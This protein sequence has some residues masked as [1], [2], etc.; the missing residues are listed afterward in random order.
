MDWLATV[1]ARLGFAVDQ[2]L[3]YGTGGLAFSNGQYRNHDF[4]N[5]GS[6]GTGLMDAKGDMGTGWTVGGGL[7]LALAPNWS[8]SAEYL[9]VRFDGKNYSGTAFNQEN[10]ATNDF[11]FSANPAEFNV[12]R[13]GLNYQFGGPS[14]SPSADSPLK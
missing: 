6:C 1:R 4:C 7:A 10:I 5:T 13:L 2:W 12:I 9:F 3:I 8:A 14:R 11:R